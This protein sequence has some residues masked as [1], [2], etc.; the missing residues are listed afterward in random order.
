[1]N[2][3]E[4][5]LHNWYDEWIWH[6]QNCLQLTIQLVHLMPSHHHNGWGYHGSHLLIPWLNQIRC[7]HSDHAIH[8]I[9][10]LLEDDTHGR[11]MDKV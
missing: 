5:L 9:N 8:I 6:V 3:I 7:L 10:M 1:M 4:L 11:I 2:V